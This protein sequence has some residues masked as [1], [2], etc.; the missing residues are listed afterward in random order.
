MK[1]LL[2]LLGAVTLLVGSLR[3][4]TAERKNAVSISGNVTN[5]DGDFGTEYKN[6]TANDINPGFGIGFHHYLNRYF[7]VDGN[8]SIGT[9]DHS[10][11]FGSFETRAID[12]TGM[13]RYK[14]D[15]GWILPEEAQ[16]APYLS[17]GVGAGNV[18]F[19]ITRTGQATR[20]NDFG[21]LDIEGGLGLKFKANEKFAIFAQF[22]AYL[23]FTDN[24]DG[25]IN[26][27]S[28]DSY[29]I[30]SLGL[31]YSI[32]KKKDGDGDGVA[33]SKD[34]CASTPSGVSVD[35]NGCP[36]DGD[37]DGIPDHQDQCPDIAGTPALK[38]CPDTDNDGIKDSEDDCPNDAGTKALNG[39]PDADSDGVADKD[40]KCPGT[41]K[42]VKVNGAGC[43]MDTDG[44]GILDSQDKCPNT[45]GT[46]ENNGCPAPP[47]VDTI[48]P[49]ANPAPDVK[50]AADAK[51]VA[52]EKPAADAKPKVEAPKTEAPKVAKGKMSEKQI[53]ERV[54]VLA[55]DLRFDT[56]DIK[57]F[58]RPI[59]S[60]DELAEIMIDYPMI[61]LTCEG[62]ADSRAS[63]EYNLKLS[64]ER[65]DAVKGYLVR[66]GVEP[67]RINAKGYG[68]ANPI[69]TNDT[70][71]GR[72]ENR[73]VDLK[74]V[75]KKSN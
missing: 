70:E 53:V 20:T 39:C 55:K 69:A 34:Q 31:T 41:P 50:P 64:Q 1:K 61:N 4:Q 35:D 15:N 32:G 16:F 73:R 22:M 29:I 44:D 45:K 54:E 27:E 38:G 63:E 75:M 40:D 71:E 8:L 72:R 58:N 67:S 36:L 21:H 43:E 13:L 66:K 74:L 56:D 65:A 7:D 11:T 57:L 51:P 23:P 2:F 37:L 52:E 48:K 62:H 19:D 24:V 6:F 26:G 47:K 9:L 49:V 3:A 5:Y 68:E 42:G 12:I 25:F 28:D 46:K 17:L 30:S 18:K 14:F 33:D 59:K 10:G 60:L